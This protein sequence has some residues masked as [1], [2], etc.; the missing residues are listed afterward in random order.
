MSQQ[1]IAIIGA[2]I[3]GATLG[4][5]LIHHGIPTV[6]YERHTPSSRNGYGITLHGASYRRLLPILD[7][8]EWTFRRRLT[9]DGAAGGKGT[10]DPK[11]LAVPGEVGSDSFRAHRERLERLL[12]ESLDIRWGHALEKVEPSA[13]GLSLCFKKGQRID[14]DSV[15]SV[16][17]VHANTRK[18]ILPRLELNVL[19]YVA[20]NGKRKVKQALFQEL[21]APAMKGS[22]VAETQRNGATL[23]ISIND[24]TADEVSIG[25]IYSRPARRSTDVLYKPNRPVSGASDIPDEFYQEIGA[26]RDLE[27][28]FPA[29]F[30][31]EALRV[32]RVLT[33]LMRTSEVGLTDLS[34][35]ADKGVY[36]MGDSIHAQQIL[37]GEGANNAIIDGVDMA[38]HIASHGIRSIPDWYSKNYARW[39]NGI[40]QGK[41]D[42]EEMHDSGK[43]NL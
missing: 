15:I 34:S 42:I 9:V 27:Q 25:W 4:R 12:R 1:P 39:T 38:E 5:C 29:I 33:W 16:D 22:V 18:S 23:H 32:D 37:G 10:I 41:K 11:K 13:T 3:G 26:L 14:Q 8:D 20:F 31:E 36:F 40:A 43:S 30:N 2:G 28:P 21:Y 7:M 19:P 35:A 6:L 17:G 24:I